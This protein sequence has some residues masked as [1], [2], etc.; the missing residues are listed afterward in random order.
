MAKRRK[1]TAPSA[2]DL[3]KIEEEFRRETSPNPGMAPIA[4]VAAE[5]AMNMNAVDPAMR[6]KLAELDKYRAI[7]AQ[8][9]V[10]RLIP[11]DAVDASVLTRDR[12]DLNPEDFAELKAAIL[13]N[14]LRM[15]VEVCELEPVEGQPRYGLISGYRRFRAVSELRGQPG[16]G[17]GVIEAL[18]R[19][20]ASSAASM[21]AMVEENEIRSDLTHFERGRI[22]VL[23]AQNGVYSSVE[24]ATAKLFAFASKAKRSKI[25]SFAM[26]FER[27]GDVL[28][29][30]LA[31]K[32]KQ[33]LAIAAGLRDG[34]G[35][36]LRE[37]LAAAAPADAVEEWAVVDRVLSGF[38][39]KP[40]SGEK[41]RGGRPKAQV[42]T[43]QTQRGTTIGWSR[44]GQ[45]IV[46]QLDGDI[47][48]ADMQEV[49][50]LLKGAV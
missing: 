8:G 48:D 30:P 18:V 20:A 39:A 49:I 7:E 13:A 25:R 26:V 47:N 21:E 38:V 2:E 16:Q 17:A 23:A 37:G 35:D 31:L 32:E 34:A 41:P 29:F 19:P 11:I 33:G 36:A 27:L 4:Q 5:S 42:E 45:G 50:A 3:N 24:E 9:L 40:Q 46:I 6:A 44:K 28:S 1:L 15:P 22:A 14:G 10:A 43:I 12:M